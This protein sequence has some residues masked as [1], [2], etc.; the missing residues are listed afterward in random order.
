MIVKSTTRRKV[1]FTRLATNRL[2]IIVNIHD[3]LDFFLAVHPE[4]MDQTITFGE[5]RKLTI[6]KR[7]F[8]FLF[9]LLGFVAV[10]GTHV[11][12]QRLFL[13]EALL[14]DFTSMI[15]FFHVFFHVVMHRVLTIFHCIAV[16]ADKVSVSILRISD[17]H[18][19]VSV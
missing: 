4:A 15:E 10:L 12:V 13:Q 9:L 3:R 5:C 18:G 7:A 8:E 17:R 16:R 2:R 1:F 14:A 6:I 11:Q 19:L